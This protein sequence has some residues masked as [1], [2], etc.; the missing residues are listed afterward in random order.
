MDVRRLTDLDLDPTD[1]VVLANVAEHG[2]HVSYILPERGT[3][4]WHF[5]VGIYASYQQPEVITFGLTHDVG[6]FVINALARHAREGNSLASDALYPGLLEGVS[7]TL[8]PVAPVWYEPLLGV[9]NWFYRGQFFPV[10]QCVWPD[11]SQ[12][13]PW[14]SEFP[15]DWRWAQPLLWHEDR[16]EALMESILGSMPG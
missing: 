14:S 12:V 4:G 1:R 2:V 6:H 3:P 13:F 15:S 10:M 11:H 8:K 16:R 9:A 5:S 7:C